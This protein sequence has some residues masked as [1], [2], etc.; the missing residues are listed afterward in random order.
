MRDQ[1]R[2]AII[3]TVTHNNAHHRP[4]ANLETT[5]TNFPIPF[6]TPHEEEGGSQRHLRQ[7][8]RVSVHKINRFL[9]LFKA[10]IK[11]FYLSR[12]TFNSFFCLFGFC[13]SSIG[14]RVGTYSSARGTRGRGDVGFNALGWLRV[15]CSRRSRN[16]RYPHLHLHLYRP[17]TSTM[18]SSIL[19]A[20][21]LCLAL[22]AVTGK[23]AFC[24]FFWFYQILENWEHT[25]RLRNFMSRGTRRQTKAARR[26]YRNM[27][28]NERVTVLSQHFSP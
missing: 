9:I 4:P 11:L 26:T 24:I 5:V 7:V 17:S 12:Q 3:G 2:A 18:H 21:A 16:R 25:R 20:S 1:R 22:S 10:A 27:P 15:Q 8:L 23:S 19:A 28:V 13:D 14:G 6:I